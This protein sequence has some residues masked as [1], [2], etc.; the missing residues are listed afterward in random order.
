MSGAKNVE[1]K[2][3]SYLRH[4]SCSEIQNEIVGFYNLATTTIFDLFSGSKLFGI[5]LKSKS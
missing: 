1:F 3:I 4:G 2:K 5:A